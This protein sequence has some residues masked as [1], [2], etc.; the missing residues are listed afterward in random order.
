MK[1]KIVA[2]TRPGSV[3]GSM[4]RHRVCEPAA[5]VEG[6]RLLDL[7][8]DRGEEAVQDPDREGEVERRVREDERQVG[9]D[10]VEL[11]E[12]AVEAH[13]ERGRREHL[14]DEDEQQERDPAR[15]SGTG[16]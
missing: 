2:V 5:A 13:D 15:G 12:L 14:R 4:T 8:R 3:S 11:E 6:R 7:Q 10:Q 9:V 1:V 16:P